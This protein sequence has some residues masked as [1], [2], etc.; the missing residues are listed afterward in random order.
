MSW[1]AL[2]VR[3]H[4]RSS[5]FPASLAASLVSVASAPGASGAPILEVYD[6]SLTTYLPS[7]A[8]GVQDVRPRAIHR[9]VHLDGTLVGGTP[10][11]LPIAGNPFGS[12]W[13]G[14]RFLG[15][16]R[17]DIGG[18]T[19][20]EVDIA[21]PAT[22]PWVIGRTYNGLQ[23]TSGG[24][25]R[26]SDGYQG[27]DWF[28]TSQPE[29]VLYE[30]ASDDT[31]DVLYILWG[32]DRYI[33]LE[34][35]DDGGNPA[36]AVDLYK[37][38]NGSA[39]VVEFA[40]GTTGEPDTYTYHIHS[41]KVVFFGFDTDAGAAAGQIWKIIGAGGEVAYVGDKTTGSTA[42]TNGYDSGGKI[43]E[44]RDS[45]G[46]KYT[47]TYTTLDGTARLTKVKA[48][49]YNGL[50]WQ[51]VAHV[52]YEYY[53]TGDNTDGD[54]GSLKLARRNVKLTAVGESLEE[55]Q[56][57][58]YD[59]DDTDLVK[60]VLGP[61]GCRN[62]DYNGAADSTFD[63]D[64]ETATLAALKP[65]ADVYLEY[66]TSKRVD[67]MFTN[68]ACGCSGQSAGTINL[69]YGSASGFSGN[70]GYDQEPYAYTRLDL[71]GSEWGL[72]YTDELGGPLTHVQSTMKPLD[73]GVS[74]TKTWITYVERYPTDGQNNDPGG[75]IKYIT[76]PSAHGAWN[77]TTGSFTTDL[78]AIA[79]RQLTPSKAGDDLDGQPKIL[80]I[81]KGLSSLATRT[82]TT[83]SASK[84][85]GS[86]TTVELVRPVID[87]VNDFLGEETDYTITF[88][89]GDAALQ[90][91]EEELSYPAVATSRNGSGSSLTSARYF[92]DDGSLAF[93]EST[94][95]TFDYTKVEEGLVTERRRDAKLNG[96]FPTGD[97]PNG[98]WGITENGDGLD[99]KTTHT[100]DDQGRR[101]S[102][103]LPS[104]R[105]MK[106]HYTKLKD[107]RLVTLSIPRVVGSTYYGPV[108][109]TVT[110]QA[111]SVEAQ[112]SIAFSGGS[113]TT[114]PGNW[115]DDTKD[116]PTDA[117]STGTLARL[118]TTLY[119]E[120]G[121]RVEE[122]RVYF[123]VPSTGLGDATDNYDPTIF[124]YDDGGRRWREKDA[125]GTITRWVFDDIGRNTETWVGTNDNSFTGGEP[126]GTDNMVKV[127]L[128][129]YP[130]DG[131]G[132][133]NREHVV[134]K[135]TLY[136]VDGTTD[137]RVYEYVY[138]SQNRLA[139]SKNPQAPHEVLRYNA[140]DQIIARGLYSSSSGLTA[141]T[142]PITNATNRIALT[143]WSFDDRG[144]EDK[145]TR[146]KVDPSDGSLDD[147]LTSETWYGSDDRVAE[148]KA[149]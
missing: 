130:T 78:A 25:H 101:M 72:Q 56:Y 59:N 9:A 44:A 54:N 37:A 30:H 89:S 23:E 11:G 90:V 57:F 123:D 133:G 106:V 81:F 47:Y 85:I 113:T 124:A 17:L 46:R 63:D 141:S 45:K 116:T 48:E 50:S 5:L 35:L 139:V 117:V 66:D 71:P 38:V 98:T 111:G 20:T 119:S 102:T 43:T 110:N 53:Q 73:S 86:G 22:V 143:E 112:G 32:A 149:A 1:S 18:Y 142:N 33:E 132:E 105:I 125:T 95:G 122:R 61:E 84:T 88:H 28:Q 42:I 96:T 114:A 75:S 128:L 107:G 109:Y 126:T 16:V 12:P 91:K 41:G 120:P 3:T 129:E 135:R 13:N 39:G 148:P 40:E 31:K 69:T 74:T 4:R 104:N 29:I 97:D 65:Y 115:I 103:T 49:L 144:R 10:F 21:L 94:G 51:E 70:S 147:S 108:S 137:Q 82:T 14:R 76:S 68:G 146:H 26:H 34:R 99:L 79:N 7:A 127:A 15:P 67:S 8:S 55:V 138:D 93:V 27:R 36:T 134:T 83:T 92:R 80:D 77:N 87:K 24:A 62:Y 52:D 136:V 131:N 60:L 64:F 145:S 118:T 19:P 100:Y 2:S 121:T 58:R 140:S 6:D